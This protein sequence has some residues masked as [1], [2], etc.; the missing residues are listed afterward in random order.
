MAPGRSPSWGCDQP[1]VHRHCDGHLYDGSTQTV[2]V[3]LSDWTLGGGSGSVSTG[4][5]IAVTTSYRNHSGASADNT[6]TY[7]F[8]TAPV[9]LDPGKIVQS[10]QPPSTVS[11]GHLHVFAVAFSAGSSPTGPITSGV[12]STLCSD[13]SASLTLSGNK[14]QIWGC[15]G[16]EAQKWT[17]NA[18][19]TLT[20]FGKCL[21][22][23]AGT[24]NH[25]L[26]QLWACNGTGSQQWIP[27]SDG[28]LK[29]P[30]LTRCLDDP[31]STTNQG[32]QLQLYDCNGT[33]AQKW[34]LP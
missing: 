28:S 34:S 26:I 24:A 4:N 11:N 3:T 22:T 19:G 23:G 5:T 10:V 25:T 13:D 9:A 7:V 32:V 17:V 33:S 21:D 12:S 30:Q 6:K 8:A 18:D 14:I 16:S 1:A 27:Q 20:V 31:N 29:H 2:S 15:N